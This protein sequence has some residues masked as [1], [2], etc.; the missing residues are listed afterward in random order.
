MTRRIQ[1]AAE[2]G[3]DRAF[4]TCAHRSLYATVYSRRTR[5][6][7]SQAWCTRFT[8]CRGSGI[9]NDRRV[10]K[11]M[12]N[13]SLTTVVGGSKHARSELVTKH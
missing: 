2:K 7:C 5:V 9:R 3:M 12:R 4:R 13:K 11:V 10:R 8:F 6:T 1:K